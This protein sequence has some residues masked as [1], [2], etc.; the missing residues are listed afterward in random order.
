MSKT[1]VYNIEDDFQMI[2]IDDSFK[3]SKKEFEFH[4]KST[5]PLRPVAVA[6]DA[7]VL[8]HDYRMDKESA[9]EDEGEG[10]E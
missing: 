6:M 3:P 10:E 5:G 8:I 9:R 4:L 2:K 1:K 7:V